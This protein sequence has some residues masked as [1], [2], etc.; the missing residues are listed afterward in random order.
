MTS[1]AETDQI[2]R[3]LRQHAAGEEAALE[4]LMPLVY[5]Q[6]RRLA[7]SQL[8][9]N[10]RHE[11][12]NTTAL[13]HEAY[14]KLQGG[15]AVDWQ[16]RG[17]FYAICSRTMRRLIVDYA[18]RRGAQKRG[19]DKAHVTLEPHHAALANEAE[20]WLAVDRALDVLGSFNERLTRVVECRFFAGLSEEETAEA[21]GVSRRTVQRDWL[22]ARAWLRKEL[23]DA[24]ATLE[25]RS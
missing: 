11:T 1:R 18:R 4:E 10:K 20:A 16:D 14:L 15:S 17:H 3:L 9:R 12:L 5:Q 19:G 2:S 25:K 22:R 8:A 7:R 13:V 21:L 24:G 23:E 6:L